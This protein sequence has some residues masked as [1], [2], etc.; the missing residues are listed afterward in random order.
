[1]ETAF[2]VKIPSMNTN[3]FYFGIILSL[4]TACGGSDSTSSNTSGP[5]TPSNSSTSGSTAETK[6]PEPLMRQSIQCCADLKLEKAVEPYTQIV[7][8]LAQGLTN[9]ESVNNLVVGLQTVT[10]NSNDFQ[11]FIESLQ[12]VDGSDLA[13]V[14]AIIGSLSEVLLVR[15]QDS[16]SPSGAYDLAFGYSRDADS[17]WAQ[18]GVEPK[19]PY[20]D[21][22]QSYSWGSRE[23]VQ[24]TDAAREKQLG[25][26]DLG[27]TP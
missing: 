9:P 26:M 23:Q 13:A 12:K 24:E 4:S 6:L 14:R 2:C 10:K 19:S 21:G 1:M 17:G 18:V 5:A 7:A 15:L 16:S 27:A 3:V 25:N 22:I 20:G 8:G 11:P